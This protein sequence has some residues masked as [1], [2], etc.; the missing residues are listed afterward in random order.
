MGAYHDQ[1]SG[2]SNQG[3]AGIYQ[4]VGRGWQRLQYVTDP[5]GKKYDSFS[6]G[7]VSVHEPTKQ[8]IVGVPQYVSHSE[9]VVFGKI[10]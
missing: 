6:S 7:G 4:R 10:N 1:V 3:S 9:K 5:G 8:F 2:V